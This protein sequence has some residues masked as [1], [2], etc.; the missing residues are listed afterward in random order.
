[1][2]DQLQKA[3][4]E[5][6]KLK[7]IAS[8]F[9][10]NVEV[11]SVSSDIAKQQT[12]LQGISKAIYTQCR[13]TVVLTP[14][15]FQ[16]N[17]LANNWILGRQSID[18]IV[19]QYYQRSRFYHNVTNCPLDSPFYEGSQCNK[20]QQP[21]PIFNMQSS[22][23]EKCPFDTK[24][25]T[26]K[27]VCEQ[28]PHF[29]DYKKLDNFILD[30]V[31]LPA[32][33][34]DTTPCPSQKPYF[35]GKCVACRLP[36]YW[37]VRQNKCKDCPTGQVFDPN[38]KTC[39]TPVGN[40]LSYLQGNSRW[41]TSAGNFT[42][43]LRERGELVQNKPNKYAICGKDSP[44]YDGVACISC[45]YEFNLAQ[46]KCV[47]APAG[48]VFN[49]NIHEYIPPVVGKSTNPTAANLLNTSAPA[50]TSNPCDTKTPFFDGISCI[51][52]P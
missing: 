5:V 7:A 25:N 47:N 14:T 6:A 11:S 45:P 26:D 3:K 2:L 38:T 33:P 9:P 42:N 24:L 23:C 41:V 15:I 34:T 35:E 17:L 10:S 32:A 40:T 21:T 31:V 51:K 37:N 44:Y 16:T 13:T 8:K 39:T 49:P 22:K 36:S 52:C 46:K 48:T 29:T 12:L 43:I 18:N 27:H 4:D 50:P 19:E 1:M 28:I 30:G 20:C